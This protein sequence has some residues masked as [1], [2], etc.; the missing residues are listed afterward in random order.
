MAHYAVSFE[1][2]KDITYS[3]RYN[4]LTEQ[5]AKAPSKFVWDETTSFALVETT[6]TLEAFADRLYLKSL[7]N[8]QTDILLVFDPAQSYAIARGPIKYEA[9]LRG[10]FRK[11]VRK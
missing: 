5:I 2:K 8:S 3:A 7:V 4:S 9:L 10:K 1:L 6:E 11:Y